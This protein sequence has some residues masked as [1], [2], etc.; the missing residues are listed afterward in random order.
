MSDLR[1]PVYGGGSLRAGSGDHCVVLI[2]E[3]EALHRGMHIL[4]PD[5]A[6]KIAA[7]LVRMADRSEEEETRNE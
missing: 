4:T 7:A 2:G 5:D 1:V 3:G 6:R